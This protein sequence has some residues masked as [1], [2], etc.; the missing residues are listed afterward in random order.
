MKHKAWIIGLAIIVLV[1]SLGAII[2]PLISNHIDSQMQQEVVA[3]AATKVEAFP[4]DELLAMREAAEQYNRVLCSGTIS[5]KDIYDLYADKEQG[6]PLYDTLL[7][8]TDDGLM[9]ILEIPIIDITVPI[10][11]GTETEV[12]SQGVGHI[13]GTSLPIGGTGTHVAVSGHSGMA[14]QRMLTDLPDMEIGNIFFIHILGETLTYQVDQIKTVLPDDIS[15]LAIDP[16]K[17]YVTLI[18][19]TPYGVN[20]HRLLVRGVRIENASI[21][22]EKIFEETQSAHFST[23]T[24]EYMWALFKGFLVVV[25]VAIV[26]LIAKAICQRKKPQA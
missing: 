21:D 25:T 1:L 16:E 10:Y 22:E 2:Y 26:I 11:H 8:V 23:W 19:C 18:T 24:Q 4:D 12:L 14:G 7:N 15:D 13:Y 17:D 20:T 5:G 9:G 6:K 3:S